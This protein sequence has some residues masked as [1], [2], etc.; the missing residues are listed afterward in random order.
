[1]GDRVTCRI[2][3]AADEESGSD[4]Y[5]E[6]CA[7]SEHTE[8]VIALAEAI[9]RMIW[10]D[11]RCPAQNLVIHMEDAEEII[12]SMGDREQWEVWRLDAE[13]LRL[14]RYWDDFMLFTVNGDAIFGHDPNE[15][16][17][18]PPRRLE[19]LIVRLM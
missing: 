15:E 19:D 7:M 12:A 17:P 6:F 4:T 8:S 11:E 5:A 1:M 10:E 2:C 16:G 18:C 9:G 14:S 13:E 3:Q